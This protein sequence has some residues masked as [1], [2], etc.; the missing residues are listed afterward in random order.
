VTRR[1]EVAAAMAYFETTDDIALLHRLLE[2]VAPR[3]KRMVGQ[4]LARGAEDNTPGPA[5]L[6]AA[7]VPASEPDALRTLRTSNDFPLLQV[8]ARSIGQRIEAIEIAA[9][10][11]FPEGARVVVPEKPSYPPSGR[12]LAGTVETTGTMLRVRLDNGETWQGPPSLAA[13]ERNQ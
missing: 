12:K 13:L 2:E 11:E 4:F 8:M 9:S 7:K 6:R 10:A 3:A 1:E 5:D